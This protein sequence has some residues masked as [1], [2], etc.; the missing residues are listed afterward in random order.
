MGGALSRTDEE[1]KSEATYLKGIW[2]RR[3]RP[4]IKSKLDPKDEA[5]YLGSMRNS[6]MRQWI[7]DAE[8]EGEAKYFRESFGAH[9]VGKSG[10]S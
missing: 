5:N 6:R 2:K 3:T 7:R 9:E 1:P 8:A 4:K 10:K